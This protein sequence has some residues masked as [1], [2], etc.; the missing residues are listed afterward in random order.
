MKNFYLKNE[1]IALRAY[2]QNAWQQFIIMIITTHYFEPLKRILSI[3]T[4]ANVIIKK[5]GT[6]TRKKDNKLEKRNNKTNSNDNNKK[7]KKKRKSVDDKSGESDTSSKKRKKQQMLDVFED[8]RESSND[9]KK[10]EINAINKK[11]LDNR[12]Q[13]VDQI[14]STRNIIQSATTVSNSS[15]VFNITVETLSFL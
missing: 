11:L 3:Q 15:K 12:E 1:S 9:K 8:L 14:S 13:V 7:L 5:T 4:G 10:D 2:C 6:K